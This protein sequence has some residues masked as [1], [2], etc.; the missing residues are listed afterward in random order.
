MSDPADHDIFAPPQIPVECFC[1]HCRRVYMSDLILKIEIDGEIHHAC[2]VEGCTAM[3]YGFDILPTQDEDEEDDEFD[4][5]IDED[6]LDLPEGDTE[7]VAFDPPQE[8]S[9][10]ADAEDDDEETSEVI[11]EEVEA[12]YFTREDFDRLKATGEVERRI[13]QIREQWRWSRD[14]K[15]GG[16][17][18]EDI[19]F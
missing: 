5:E 17:R 4:E 13:E 19:P 12:H 14:P 18:D 2:P 16:F 15:N 9:P 7:E 8:W 11:E 1:L 10:E 3:G 6:D